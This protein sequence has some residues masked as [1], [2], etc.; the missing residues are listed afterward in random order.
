MIVFD[1][2]IRIT[3]CWG[4]RLFS[5]DFVIFYCFINISQIYMDISISCQNRSFISICWLVFLESPFSN[6][7]PCLYLCI[8]LEQITIIHPLLRIGLHFSQIYEQGLLFFIAIIPW[9]TEFW[10]YL[11]LLLLEENKFF[12]IFEPWIV[13]HEKNNE[14]PTRE[15]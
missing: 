10:I 9:L 2:L 4:L 1:N 6:Y 13:S 14:K 3:K 8:E 7:Y 11:Y 15:K 12:E 5:I